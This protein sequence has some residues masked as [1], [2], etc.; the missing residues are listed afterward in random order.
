MA[1]S[2]PTVLA[3][4][5]DNNGGTSSLTASFTPPQNKLV[6]AAVY[7]VKTGGGTQPT[8]S[9][10]SVTYT[11]EDTI[12]FDNSSRLTVFRCLDS[13]TTAGQATIDFG[14]TSQEGTSWLIFSVD[15]AWTGGTNGDEAVVQSVTA[16]GT[17]QAPTVTLATF[18]DAGNAAFGIVA[19][20]DNEDTFVAGSGF[21]EV[22]SSGVDT[23][24]LTLTIAE[25]KASSDTVI[26][27]S[28][29]NTALSWGMI[30]L[31]IKAGILS[32]T[33]SIIKGSGKS[34]VIVGGR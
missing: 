2:N 29:T 15:D 30:G 10:N 7:N 4:G 31:E 24:Q 11:L 23:T 20:R 19:I 33:N 28:L 3:N 22:G 14:A 25:W 32:A 5:F 27:A 16:S 6:L 1:V 8:M 34:R 21:A 26:D 18:G 17:D 12:A 13:S 9:G